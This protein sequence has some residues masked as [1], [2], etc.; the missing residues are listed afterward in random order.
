MKITFVCSSLECGGAEKALLFLTKK[1]NDIGFQTEII[2]LFNNNGSDFYDI[3]DKTVD[4]KLNL[5]SV[6]Q[7][8]FYKFYCIFRGILNLRHHIKQNKSDIIISFLS[9]VN[10]ITLIAT[11]N[12]NAP[13][14]VAERNDPNND[15]HNF[16]FNLLRKTL[17]ILASRIILLSSRFKEYFPSKVQK[18]CVVIPNSIKLKY[19]EL[20]ES[21]YKEKLIVSIGRLSDE[22]DHQLLIK[23]F[24]NVHT[25]IPDWK[26]EIY[27]DGELR[28][29]LS[30][31]IEQLNISK[32]V[33]LKGLTHTPQQVL[34]NASFSVLP[35]KFEGFPNVILESL[36]VKTP[37][38]SFRNIGA[39][40]DIIVNEVN[41]LL[42]NRESDE[43]LLIKNLS[44][45]ILRLTSDSIL[46][47]KMSKNARESI[48]KFD[49]DL[50]FD[51]WYK[52]IMELI[53]K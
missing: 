15:N 10:I 32:Q 48:S 22:K 38:L 34:Q 49:S 37:V 28:D 18:K 35:S 14:L 52:L 53:K 1:F 36:S 29:Q 42:I 24:H 41:G 40:N 27:G 5:F 16:L 23:A 51:I 7:S 3:P 20:S 50:I 4:T 9:W 6:N 39:I 13:I 31:L 21:I 30:E 46:L 25:K 11:I 45:S 43:K 2:S 44:D 17:F 33:I 8:G 12:I 26:L 19:E 47:E